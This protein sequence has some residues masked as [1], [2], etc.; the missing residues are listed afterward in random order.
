VPRYEFVHLTLGDS[1]QLCD[2]RDDERMP[3][4]VQTIRETD[5]LVLQILA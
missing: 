1:Q 4:A 2:I 3:L 5:G